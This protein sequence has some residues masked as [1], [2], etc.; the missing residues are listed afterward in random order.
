MGEEEEDGRARAGGG[1]LR[2]FLSYHFILLFSGH[3]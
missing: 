1:G 2:Y 3:L